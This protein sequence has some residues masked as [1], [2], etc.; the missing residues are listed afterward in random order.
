M[1][2]NMADRSQHRTLWLVEHERDDPMV[3]HQREYG[4]EEASDALKRL[5]RDHAGDG[6][7][8]DPPIEPLEIGRRYDLHDAHGWLATYWLSEEP[9]AKHDGMLTAIVSP[10]AKQRAH[11]RVPRA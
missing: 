3:L 1:Q 9:I 11:T 2:G 5:L 8:V 10:A 4:R 6:V 7:H